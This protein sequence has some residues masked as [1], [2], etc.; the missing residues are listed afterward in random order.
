MHKELD[1]KIG[2]FDLL[3]TEESGWHFGISSPYRQMADELPIKTDVLKPKNVIDGLKKN[4]E[5]R[6]YLFLSQY[7]A[8]SPPE[9]FKDLSGAG[10][11]WMQYISFPNS[12]H[13]GFLK[14]RL[15]IEKINQRLSLGTIEPY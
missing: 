8:F 10:K 6:F 13:L 4:P 14:E 9:I 3:V 7:D 12:G 1:K 5:L 2:F 11:A 15:I